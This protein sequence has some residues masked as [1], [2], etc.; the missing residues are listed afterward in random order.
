[1]IKRMTFCSIGILS[2]GLALGLDQASK[3]WLLQC[4]PKEQLVTVLSFFNLV[5]VW[6]H[7]IS[8]GL[9]AGFDQ[10]LGLVA[11]SIVIS[12]ILLGWLVKTDS[13][14]VACALG[15]V[16]GGAIANVIDRLHYG[17]VADFFDFHIGRY[18]WPAFNIAD[19]CIFIGVVL[20]CWHSMFIENS[21]T[22]KGKPL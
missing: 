22:H 19:S 21:T 4:V 18:H 20:L 9:F 10:R 16:I 3:A 13:K 17:A 15:L 5:L 8:F 6:N 2:A 14:L 12:L 11:L 7:G 1:M